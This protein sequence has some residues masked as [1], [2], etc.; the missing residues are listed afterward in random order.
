MVSQTHQDIGK[1]ASRALG[2]GVFV[3]QDPSRA[4]EGV[5]TK[6]TSPFV[7]PQLPE[8]L[9]EDVGRGKGQEMVVA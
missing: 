5:F 4:G 1:V 8:D 6:L 9:D 7:L 2:V 3:A